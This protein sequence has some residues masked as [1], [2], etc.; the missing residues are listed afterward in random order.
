MLLSRTW[1]QVREMSP[2]RGRVQLPPSFTPAAGMGLAFFVGPWTAVKEPD[3]ALT[4][5]EEMSLSDVGT[6]QPVA[7]SS[8]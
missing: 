6:E 1:P 4:S 8:S 2:V 3:E 7:I 5:A